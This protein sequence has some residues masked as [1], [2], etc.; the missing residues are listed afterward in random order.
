M[1]EKALTERIKAQREEIEKTSAEIFETE[2]KK[3]KNEEEETT[4]TQNTDNQSI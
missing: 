1:R 2:T 4:S 3:L